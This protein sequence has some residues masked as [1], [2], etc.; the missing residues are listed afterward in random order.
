MHD[1]GELVER[2]RDDDPAA[3]AA[4]AFVVAPKKPRLGVQGLCPPKDRKK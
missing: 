3:R 2:D 1:A 4:Y